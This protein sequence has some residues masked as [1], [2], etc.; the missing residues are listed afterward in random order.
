MHFEFQVSSPWTKLAEIRRECCQN[1]RRQNCV[2]LRILIIPL[3][4]K[5]CLFFWGSSIFFPFLTL[6]SCKKNNKRMCQKSETRFLRSMCEEMDAVLIVFSC[7]N[8]AGVELD[9]WVRV[10]LRTYSY[11]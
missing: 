8:L 9:L 10:A 3:I 2:D 11:F 6:S 5:L 7:L 1:V 4:K